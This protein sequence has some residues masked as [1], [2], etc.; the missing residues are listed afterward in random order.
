MSRRA[1]YLYGWLAV[2][3]VLTVGAIFF[4]RHSPA[5]QEHPI[6]IDMRRPVLIRQPLEVAGIDEGGEKGLYCAPGGSVA[7]DQDGGDATYRFYVPTAGRYR[8]WGYCRWLDDGNGG[9]FTVA[10]GDT[11]SSVRAAARTATSDTPSDDTPWQWIPLAEAPLS[12]GVVTMTLTANGDGFAVRRLFL[13]NNFSRHPAESLT[14]P[15]DVFFDDFDG[16]E[17]GEFDSWSRVSGRWVVRR[18]E[19]MKSPA[20]QILTGKSSSEALLNVGFPNWRAYSLRLDCRVIRFAPGASA[21]VR[22]YVDS[23]G[24]GLVLQW[25]PSDADGQVQME[26]FRETVAGIQRLDRLTVPWDTSRWSELAIEA[27]D[28][29]LYIHLDSNPVRTI[30]VDGPDGGGIGL[31]LCGDIEMAFDN[32]Q[33]LGQQEAN[34]R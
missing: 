15:N 4:L 34:T 9:G 11:Q 10:V 13:C 21:A 31:W 29:V 12:A 1:K 14:E 7:T 25:T 22:F 20:A 28:G 27:R 8:L 24:N 3:V 16:C 18:R 32:V 5:G 6:W 23:D 17:E 19:D 30:A 33:V 2:G 26:L